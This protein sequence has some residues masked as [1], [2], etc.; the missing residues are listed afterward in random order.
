MI[1]RYWFGSV[2]V[3]STRRLKYPREKALFYNE[4]DIGS[5]KLLLTTKE[6][7]SPVVVFFP[8]VFLKNVS[9]K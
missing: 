3:I 5:Q 4:A 7:M 8:I 9:Y 2:N 6:S 1:V